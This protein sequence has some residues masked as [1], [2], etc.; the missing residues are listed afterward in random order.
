MRH[1]TH[2]AKPATMDGEKTVR[3][4]KQYDRPEFTTKPTPEDQISKSKLELKMLRMDI[5]ALQ[6][7]KRRLREEIEDTIKMLTAALLEDKEE[8]PEQVKRRISRLKGALEYRG[9]YD[10]SLTER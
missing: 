4:V 3:L 10:F 8:T 2:D 5:R 1:G 7:E 6:D 9:R